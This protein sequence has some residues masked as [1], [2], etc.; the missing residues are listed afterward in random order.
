[1]MKKTGRV[2]L[3]A[4]VLTFAS[5]FSAFAGEA[6]T[7]RVGAMSGPTAM[8]MVG[9]MDSAAKGEMANTYEFADL[10][11]DASAFVAPLSAGEIDIAAVPSNL[12]GVLYNKTEGGVEVLA[13]NVLSV[14]NIVERGEEITQISD[15]KGHT[16]YATGQGATPEA[17]LRHL[18]TKNEIDP[19]ADLEIKWCADTTEALSYITKDESAIAMLPQPFVTA[20]QAQVEDLRIAL[21]LGE[22][23]QEAGDGQI[24]TGVLVVRSAFEQEHPEEVETF[25]EEYAASYELTQED[26]DAA[27][28]LIESAG[29]L[30]KA[31]LAKKAL[32][33]CG[34]AFLTGEEMKDTLSGYL[35]VIAETDAALVGGKLPEEDFYY[36]G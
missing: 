23:W 22:V 1:M 28:A 34:I 18:L 3:T 24:V 13:V 7:V 12:A 31:A 26:P 32:P 33:G 8:G 36:L 2:L 15:L 17:V 11:T 14:L 21:N 30:P 29:I 19:D 27:A 5:A 16:L 25:L 20:A 35:E 4:A 6:V 10:M 9:L